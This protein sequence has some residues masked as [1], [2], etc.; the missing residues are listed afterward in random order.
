MPKVSKL[1]DKRNVTE[2][3]SGKSLYEE[4]P[5][6]QFLIFRKNHTEFTHKKLFPNYL[7]R[8]FIRIRKKHSDGREEK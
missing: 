3:I 7:G 6:R 8:I 5:T 4:A 2:K 1:S